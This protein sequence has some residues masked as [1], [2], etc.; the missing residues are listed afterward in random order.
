MSLNRTDL[1]PRPG[2]AGPDV[3][4]DFLRNEEEDVT[5]GRSEARAKSL[6]REGSL[7]SKRDAE[8]LLPAKP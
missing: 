1:E 4:S 2:E 3:R 6:A 8:G 5:R 7:G